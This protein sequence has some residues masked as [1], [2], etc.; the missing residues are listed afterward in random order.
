MPVRVLLVNSFYYPR[1]GD[2]VHVL[3]LEKL[4]TSKGHEVAIFAMHHPENLP[5]RWST[6]W[7][8]NVEYQGRLGLVQSMEAAL[9]SM[10]SGH[11]ARRFACL[12]RAFRPDVVHMHGI[13]HHLT[14]S[15]IE[16]AKRHDLPVVWTL[17]DYRAVCPATHCVRD[18]RPCERCADAQFWQGVVGRCKSSSLARSAAAVVESYFTRLRGTLGLVDCYIAPSL[19]L[20]EVVTR[21]G[22]P[23]TRTE[24]MPNFYQP[25]QDCASPVSAERSGILFVGRLSEEKGAD[26]LIEACVRGSIALRV[27]GDGPLL[28]RCRR[29]SVGADVTFEGWQDEADVHRAME[30]AEILCV[31]SVWYENCPTVVLEAASS[32]LPVMASD[33]GGLRELLDYGRC[34]WLVPPGDAEEW[35]DAMREALHDQA[36]RQAF[37]ERARRRLLE[38]HDPSSYVAR[39]EDVYMSCE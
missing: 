15:V 11:V 8:Q 37:G 16:E 6:F 2:C 28:E 35:C 17:H 24:V 21:M 38:R 32:G 7:P 12:L 9:R 34:G 20:A 33:L 1:G 22:L 14:L 25:P 39:L 31:P 30:R 23:A 36:T 29:R 27:I 13:H 26:Y 10:R 19:F 18:G 4:L 5:S 3:A